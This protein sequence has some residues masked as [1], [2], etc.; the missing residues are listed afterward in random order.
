MYDP[1]AKEH[2]PYHCDEA[3]QDRPPS[4]LTLHSRGKSPGNGHVAHGNADRPHRS[5]Q[6]GKVLLPGHSEHVHLGSL[7][8]PPAHRSTMLPAVWVTRNGSHS[9]P[10]SFVY[11]DFST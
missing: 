9:A 6:E 8:S 7:L 3:D 2:E 1:T 10:T 5:E 4:Q 11:V